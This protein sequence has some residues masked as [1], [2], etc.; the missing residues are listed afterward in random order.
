CGRAR[1]REAVSALCAN[2]TR[3]RGMRQDGPRWSRRVGGKGDE[4]VMLDQAGRSVYLTRGVAGRGRWLFP[5]VGAVAMVAPDVRFASN[6]PPGESRPERG[7]GTD[8]QRYRGRNSARLEIQRRIQSY[9][10]EVGCHP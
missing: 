9:L 5:G 6:E 2:G 4:G 8:R 7:A 10:P 1:E 3:E